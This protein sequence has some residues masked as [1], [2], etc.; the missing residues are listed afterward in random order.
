MSSLLLVIF[1][2][3]RM[4]NILLINPVYPVREHRPLDS[5]HLFR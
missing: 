3:N 2:R 1:A 4:T 5:R